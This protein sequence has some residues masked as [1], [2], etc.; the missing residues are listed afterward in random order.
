MTDTHIVWKADGELPEISSPLATADH[1]FMVTTPGLLTCLDAKSGKMLWE[2]ELEE[3]V[4]A[5]PILVGKFVYLTDTQGITHIFEPAGM[6]KAVAAPSI[7][8]A[9]YAT[10]AFVG[11]RIYIRG[12]EHLYC[13]AAP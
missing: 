10:A 7:G 12:K 1:V 9:V 3:D 5:S 13:I 11:G 8:E 2:H 4:N 6:F